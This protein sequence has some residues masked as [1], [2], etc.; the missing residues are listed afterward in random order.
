MSSSSDLPAP[1]WQSD[2][3]Y[4]LLWD[5]ILDAV[6]VID[7]QSLIRYANPAVERLFGYGDGELIGEPLHLL[8]P[9]RLRAG[10]QRGLGSY[11]ASGKRTL[12]WATAE[13]RGL[14]RDGLEF[15]IEISFSE[16]V[17]GG[18]RMFAAVMR[19]ATARRATETQ[20][21]L[22]LSQVKAT[23][24]S[25]TDGILV[26]T[27]DN[28]VMRSNQRFIRLWN[29]P[30]EVHEQHDQQ[31]GLALM[32]EQVVD[33]DL[34]LA[35]V[36]S[37][38]NLDLGQFHGELKL[39]D[40][41]VLEVHCLPQLDQG[42][43][44]GRVWSF[45]DV[46]ERVRAEVMQVA[47]RDISEA[48]HSAPDLAALFPRIHQII[49][50]L[51]PAKNFFVA[52][53]DQA[54]DL[55]SFPYFI[56]EHDATP[57]SRPLAGGRALTDMILRSGEPLLLSPD[58]E[59]NITAHP[60]VSLMGT[61]GV[62]WL[63]IP[64]KTEHA[65]I[66]V[67]A[68]QTYS[69]KARYTQAD[70][71]LLQFVSDQVAS[72]VE[73]TRAQQQMR[74][75]EQ[76]FRSVF[77]QSP[78]IIALLTYPDG[79][80]QE[81][82]AA[83]LRAFG[84]TRE[85]ALGKTSVEL[86][87]WVDPTA[88][89]R[90][91]GLL[92]KHGSV[93][94]F[95][96]RM[97]RRNGEVFT[98]LHSG[99]MLTLG[100]RKYSLS[101]LQDISERKLAESALQESEQQ[102][103]SAFDYSAIGMALVGQDGRF[104]RVN[105]RLCRIVGYSDHELLLKTFQ[106]ITHPDDLEIDLS[107][108]RELV[109]GRVQSYTMEKRYFHRNGSMVLVLLAVSLVR[110]DRG[111]PRHFISQIEDISERKRAEQWQMH[112]SNT[113][114]MIMAESP[115][116]A[117]LESLAVFAETQAEAP[118][119]CSI[120]LLSGDGR[121][122]T[123]GAGPGIPDFF[124]QAIE[125]VEIGP[126]AG[127]CG[128][129]AATGQLV[130]VEDI[131][132]HPNWTAWREVAERA[133]LRS[134]WSHPITSA[135]NKVLG[136]FAIYRS[137][138][139]SPSAPD[140][141]LIRQSAGLASLAI[142]RAR[143]QEER[144]LAEVVFEQSIDGI[145]VTGSDGRVLMV[146]QSF[147]R[148]TGYPAAEVLGQPPD[149]LDQGRH[150]P[151]AHASRSESLADTGRWKGELWG[152]RKTG[153]IFPLALSVALVKGIGGA[154][155]HSISII[156]DVSEQK[157]QAARI[158]QLA[159]YDSLTGLPNRALFLD[160][161]EQTL[162]A[163]RRHGGHGAI[164][165]VDL[166]R[167]K[168]INDSQGHAIGDLALAEVARRFL[169]ASRK[170][171][172]LARLG[173]DEFVLIAENADHQTAVRIAN[174]LQGALTAPL[175]LAGH[176]YTVGASIGIAFYPADGHT[177]EDL[178]K[179]TDIAMYRAKAGGGGYRLYQAEMGAELEKRLSIAN[180]LARALEAGELQLYYQPQVEL[181]TGRIIG[182]EA[183]LRWNDAVLGWVNPGEFIPIAE[184]RGMMGA[185]GDWVLR[186]ACRQI[187]AW[188][189]AGLRLDGRLAINVSALQLEDP[190]IVGRLLQVVHDA[191]LLPNYFELELTES[192]MMVDP[193]RAVE[194]MEL[195]SAAGFGLS[196]D[197]FGTGYSSLAYLKRFAASQIK[198]DISFVRNM[199]TDA[200]DYTI[201]TTI[202][203]M[204]GSLGLQT[205]AEG[206]EEDG[207]AEALLA[208]GC[209]FAQGYFFGRPEPADDFAHKWLVPLVGA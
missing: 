139:S 59:T 32:L 90:Y 34:F 161:L 164:L 162:A 113:L 44:V 96:A 191:G 179:R 125:G 40:G 200:N 103:R 2:A 28:T 118:M 61:D 117:V 176:S 56:D 15:P 5:A 189:E 173:G 184:E 23:L 75:N 76:R 106:D 3:D 182:A 146:N 46:T 178:I 122:L 83:G 84:H 111:E 206:V 193:E 36:A 68:V 92:R 17:T 190:D 205:T 25:S 142:E 55:V 14:H 99:S 42:R 154:P 110:D 53:Y 123:V 97:R 19:D 109:A 80:L 152:R 153:E 108:M 93:R 8:Q 151:V 201:V 157:I 144:R 35:Q 7:V 50:E 31:L 208:L 21:R 52:L 185:L 4:R 112:Y 87:A 66:G 20:L 88:R 45:R 47:L 86:D 171:E 141:D 136:T 63:G 175:E 101:S 105:P 10:H 129:A 94:N 51:L 115:I 16:V 58:S 165:F 177:S 119:F 11:L 134:C 30:P 18:G 209:D 198:I 155:S 89:N 104:L 188:R 72:A 26:T 196:I 27:L 37:V 127:S 167:F 48:A 69:G 60:D 150:D 207:Q 160:R 12:D 159:F 67:L 130:I 124:N 128:A 81:M 158:E 82:N 138:P 145:M 65:T 181:T 43:A 166:D 195:L 116:A 147:E 170:E 192:S 126:A 172:T 202:I 183:L 33:P 203:A 156:N 24:E 199:L 70:K 49:G 57:V 13:A 133:G 91:L 78:I 54:T 1:S 85:D 64:L 169:S 95:E 74:E 120:L 140:L 194:V 135:D 9:E 6:L 131:Q 114:A 143:H 22:G 186:E 187:V 107:N 71:A 102:F 163:S 39:R 174:R 121:H 149:I 38:G 77:D 41:R 79:R 100:E 180:R 168:E 137:E 73:R 197:D 29:M 204:A 148:L 98:V 132:T 62:D